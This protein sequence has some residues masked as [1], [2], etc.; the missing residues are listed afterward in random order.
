MLPCKQ[1]VIPTK[2]AIMISYDESLTDRNDSLEST[3]WNPW[4]EDLPTVYGVEDDIVL[5]NSLMKPK[6]ICLLGSDGKQYHF[7]CK[8][9]D[10]GDMRKD[11]RLMEYVDTWLRYA[12]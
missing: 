8:R 11:S 9:E 6:R 3:E 1:V 7:L 5:M 2:R 4:N 12:F 10:S